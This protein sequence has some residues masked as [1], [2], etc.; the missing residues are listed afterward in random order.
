MCFHDR[1]SDYFAEVIAMR[2]EK[3][4]LIV[5]EHY[6]LSAWRVTRTAG[7]HPSRG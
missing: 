3:D 1:Y 7:P 4:G 5:R 2:F 6:M